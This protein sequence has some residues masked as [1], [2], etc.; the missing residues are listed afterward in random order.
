MKTFLFYDIETTGLNSAFDQI[1][2]FA[3]IRTDTQLNELER[4]SI[5]V[6]MRPDI[7]PSPGAFITHRLMPEDLSNGICEYEAALI[8]HSILNKSETISIGYNSLGFDDEFLRFTFYRNLLDPYSHQ[9]ANGCYRADLLPITTIYKVF[10]PEIIKWATTDEGKPTLKL[11][12]ITKA[13]NFITSG[14]AHNAM[15]DVEATVEL[16]RCLIKEEKSWSYSLELFDKNSEKVRIDKM[17]SNLSK[18]SYPV[19][20]KDYPIAIMV[21]HKLGADS[22]YIAPVLGIGRSY[23]YLNQTIWIRL[24]KELDKEIAQ[25]SNNLNKDDLNKN[26]SN[27]DERLKPSSLS[28]DKPRDNA[29]VIRKKDGETGIILPKLERFWDRLSD[30]QRDLA[31][32]NISIIADNSEKYA[33]FNK[34]FEYHRQFKYEL[35]PEADLDSLLYQSPFFNSTEKSEIKRF[36]KCSLMEKIEMVQIMKPSRVKSLAT[37][38]MFRNYLNCENENRPIKFIEPKIETNIEPNIEE[39]NKYLQESIVSLISKEF[40]NYME[41]VRLN[42]NDPE[43]NKRKI[44]GFKQDEKLIPQKAL[45]ELRT[46]RNDYNKLM[47]SNGCDRIKH[48]CQTENGEKIEDLEDK[49]RVLDW[50]ESYILS[51][52][53]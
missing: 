29:Y 5:T 34:I 2:Q 9:Y 42:T 4:H 17:F 10:K 46:I 22:L 3:A 40:A 33:I 12:S 6:K 30:K 23:H 41:R 48:D 38:I 11:E 28:G 27:K 16:A 13:N 47:E 14:K 44:I 20:I 51:F 37:R 24:D 31:E 39:N 21:S 49:K 36:H 45:E 25:N 15:A 43:F 53:R 19:H 1:L 18:K 32:K 7:V 35:V 50:L 26:N 8:I 52:C